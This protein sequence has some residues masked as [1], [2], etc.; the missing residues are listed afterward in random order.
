MQLTSGYLYS[1]KSLFIEMDL[2]SFFIRTTESCN[3][4]PTFN[5]L[6]F[7]SVK[8]FAGGK[9]NGNQ[10]DFFY[11]Q[12]DSEI[13]PE[14]FPPIHLQLTHGSCNPGKESPGTYSSQCYAENKRIVLVQNTSLMTGKNRLFNS[15]KNYL[16]F[17][18][19]CA[20]TVWKDDN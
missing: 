16:G 10:K 18:N 12:I 13:L 19:C 9:Q 11:I 7:N 6:L 17:R 20:K 8:V 5:S 1:R 2:T 3:V 4:F 14:H 15:N